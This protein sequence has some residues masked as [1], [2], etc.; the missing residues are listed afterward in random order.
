M[1]STWRSRK[2]WNDCFQYRRCLLKSHRM[3]FDKE[4][5]IEDISTEP[6]SKQNT[7][8]NLI[9]KSSLASDLLIS[10]F[11][12]IAFFDLCYESSFKCRTMER[13]LWTCERCLRTWP[14]NFDFCP[15]RSFKYRTVQRLESDTQTRI[16]RPISFR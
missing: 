14:A 5:N 6:A 16:R 7:T 3:W 15:E 9:N 2:K 10:S 1:I 4:I 13:G 8:K 12:K 11:R